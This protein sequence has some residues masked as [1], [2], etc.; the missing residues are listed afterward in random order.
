[1]ISN[2][3]IQDKKKVISFFNEKKFAKS[4]K[5]AKKLVKKNSFDFDLLYILGFSSVNLKN[6]FDAEI[7]F[8]KLLSVKES[9]EIYYMYGN[10]QKKLKN[11]DT[12][13]KNFENAINLNSNFSEAYN[14]LGNTKKLINKNSEAIKNFE[15]AIKT[16]NNNLE[17]HFNLAAILRENKKYKECKTIYENILKIDKNNLNAKNDLGTANSILGNIDVARK[18]FKEVLKK[19]NSF[20]KSYKNYLAITKI[21][22]QDKLFKQLENLNITDLDEKNKIDIFYSLSKGYFDLNQKKI[23][24]EYLEKAKILKKKNSSFSI[25]TQYKLFKDI[26]NYFEIN[27]SEVNNNKIEIKNIPIFILGMPRSGTTLIEQIISSHSEVFGAGELFF[28][29]MIMDKINLNLDNDFQEITNKIRYEYSQKLSNISDKKYI[30]DKLPMNFRW[31]GFILKSFPEAKIIHLDRNPMAVCWSNYKINF[32]NTGMD[33]SLNQE[34]LAEYF[35]LYRE[36]MKFWLDKFNKEII[37]INYENFVLNYDSEIKKI[38]DKLKLNWEDNV[39]EYYKNQRPI[40]TASLQ[41]ARKK[42]YQKSSETW[43]KYK[44]FLNP[45]QKILKENKIIF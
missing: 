21:E 20:Y 33:F 6:Y 22:K 17:A 27:N 30:I 16:K 23:G 31:I 4:I 2:K 26:K 7:Y 15:K 38:I 29:P 12:A 39:K 34:D 41:Q 18:C 42:V 43:K 25:K 8:K 35:V 36:L 10:V 45:M 44:D 9:A 5:L 24:F 40:E 13:I 3:F 1:M 11:Y 19:N 32:N 37:N 14:N 28:L